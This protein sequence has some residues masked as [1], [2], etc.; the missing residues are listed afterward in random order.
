LEAFYRNFRASQD[1]ASGS[2]SNP[3]AK[4]RHLSITKDCTIEA[5]ALGQDKI[6][7]K[8]AELRLKSLCDMKDKAPLDRVVDMYGWK[9]YCEQSKISMEEVEELKKKLTGCLKLKGQLDEDVNKK[10]NELK[11]LRSQHEL[12]SQR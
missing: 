1:G 4:E 5:R 2:S 10:K 12:L 8:E 9:E 3:F 11:S 7:L 6:A